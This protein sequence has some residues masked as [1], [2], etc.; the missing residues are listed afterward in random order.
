MLMISPTSPPT[1]TRSPTLYLAIDPLL[2]IVEAFQFAAEPFQGIR[3][4]LD[5][6]GGQVPHHGRDP[7]QAL[8][9]VHPVIHPAWADHRAAAEMP[10]D[11]NVQDAGLVIVTRNSL[12][13]FWASVI[14]PVRV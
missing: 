7:L 1:S 14:V 9:Q 12:V 3:R 4:W 6:S 8:G 13:T 5:A 11:W 10:R 2:N